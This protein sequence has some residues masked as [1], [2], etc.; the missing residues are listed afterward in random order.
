MQDTLMRKFYFENAHGFLKL[1]LKCTIYHIKN[2]DY[3]DFS[4][5]GECEQD[6]KSIKGTIALF[7]IPTFVTSMKDP[8]KFK[9]LV[10]IFTMW[11][12]YNPNLEKISTMCKKDLVTIKKLFKD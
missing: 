1:E 8:I 7:K 12:L 4:A 11:Y 6:K 9:E 5:T 2:E 10:T 3:L